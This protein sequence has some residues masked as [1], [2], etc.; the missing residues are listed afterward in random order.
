MPFDYDSRVAHTLTLTANETSTTPQA[1]TANILHVTFTLSNIDEP[2]V[3]TDEAFSYVAPPAHS[4][5]TRYLEV[6]DTFQYNIGRLFRD[7]EG[8]PVSL[9]HSTIGD[10]IPNL[11]L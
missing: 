7:P 6:G 5:E 4:D 3:L 8:A 10:Y 9:P 2:P 1:R 11:T